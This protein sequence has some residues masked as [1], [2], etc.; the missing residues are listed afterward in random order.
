MRSI[1]C[2]LLL[3]PGLAAARQ[4]DAA[5][6]AGPVAAL[7]APTAGDPAGLCEAAVTSAE[8]A[9]RLPLRLLGAIS[10]VESGRVDPVTG[11]ARA[12]PWT[13]NAEGRGRFFATKRDAMAAVAALQAHG[14]Q[15]IDVGCMQVNLAYH[16]HA[17]A[18]L[19]EAF[20][21]RDNALYAAR[22]LGLLYAGTRDWPHAIAAYHS[23]TPALGDAYR[24]QVVARWR[25][26]APQEARAV[27]LPYRDFIPQTRVYG[28]F[29]PAERV[30]G[31]LPRPLARR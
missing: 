12:W 31:A 23:E 5:K 27:S 9:G 3:L 10:L 18:S 13:I 21:P 14:V 20:D 24:L 4:A 22:F 11:I 17:F 1:L 19:A 26:P 30:Y 6:R 7:L 16:P 25:G 29:A 28:A 15:S 2:L 8:F